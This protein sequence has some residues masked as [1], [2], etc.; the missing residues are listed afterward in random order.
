MATTI[1]E[2]AREIPV[3]DECDVLVVGAGPAGVTAAVAAAKNKGGKV[4]LLERYATLGGMA[5]GGQVLAIPFLSDGPELLVS[6]IMDE[7]IGRLRKKPNAVFG[8]ELN[9]LGSTD[10]NVLKKYRHH[11]LFGI[12]RIR[13][14]VNV[15]PEMLK[16]V[17]NDMV[18]DYGV[19]VL[20][21]CWGVRAVTDDN[22]VKGVVFESKEGRKAILAKV[23][24]DA[25]G[26]GDIFASAG[27]EFEFS[28]F[29]TART[30]NTALVFR[31]G[32][33]DYDVYA[34]ALRQIAA[35]P[36]A[37]GGAFKDIQEKLGFQIHPFSAH[38]SDIVWINNWIPRSCMTV[39]GLTD[40]AFTM[41]NSI[42]AIIGHLRDNFPGMENAYLYDIASQVG[43]RGSRRLKG[44]YR[45]TSDN[46]ARRTGRD[47][48][49]AVT[50]TLGGA[51]E[52]P[53]IE[54]PYG[55]LVPEKLDG[56]L[57]AGRCFS[58][59][60]T[61]NEAASWIPHCVALGEA[62]GTA[63]ALS[64]HKGVQPRGV[65]IKALQKTLR[66][67]GVYLYD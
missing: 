40:T 27:A 25:T 54:I 26:D 63:A 58:S 30:S 23:V 5:T 7:W 42:G 38:R 65:D 3:Y 39:E 12:K 13:Y 14:G 9:E 51:E 2:P 53:R 18:Q 28:T 67:Q 46:I 36:H 8:P 66:S 19:K 21:H 45:L 15:D 20:C 62:A 49:I 50:P 64:L 34:K 11:G 16:I 35:N 47:D 29:S 57:A 1:F 31:V 4:V 17:L 24:V 61:A 44:V 48:L 10:E 60:E 22:T 56:L 41:T 59:E 32:G 37:Q 55:V 33:V 43:T 6:G 52:Y